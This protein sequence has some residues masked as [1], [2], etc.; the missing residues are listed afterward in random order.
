[1]TIPCYIC[2]NISHQNILKASPSMSSDGQTIGLSINKEECE[3]CGTIRSSDTSFL[4]DFYRNYY[5]LNI[6][7]NDPQYIYNG[8]GM[9]K[10]KMHFE[11]IEK[12]V[13]NQM[14]KVNSIIEIGCGSGNLLNLFNAE[15]K[16]GVEPSEDAAKHAHNIANVRNIGY[17]EIDDSEKYDLILSTCVIEHTINPNDFLKKN[18]NI[19]HDNS[20]I[21]IGLPIQDAESFDVYFL[22]HLHHFTSKQFI[23]LCQKNGFTVEK[24][25]I[26]YKC[27]TTIAYF[28]LR[29]KTIPLNILSFEKNQNF[30]ISKRWIDNLND[31]LK[32]HKDQNLVAFGFGETSFFY[33]TYTEL[34]SIIK[35]YID[36]VKAES[37]KNV[38]T[39]EEAIKTGILQNGFLVLLTNPHYHDF[40]KKKFEGVS[41]L[42]F[43]SPFS[44]NLS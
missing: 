40:L 28:V 15:N 23:Y 39:V 22:D 34:N 12:L 1:M 19:A 2:S 9:T 21:I 26:G 16:Y 33:Q 8:V 36:D 5:K 43:Y 25:E 6:A 24:F 32:S 31:F 13:G 18:W 14:H 37:T 7:N 27:M 41:N 44:N 4:N 11:W 20:L 17:E 10:S 42:K 35:F 29:K 30:Y 3:N 38:I